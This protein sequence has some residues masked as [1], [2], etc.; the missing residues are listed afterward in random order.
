MSNFQKLC[1][2]IIDLE[3]PNLEELIVELKRIGTLEDRMERSKEVEA[4]KSSFYRQLGKLKAE[5]EAAGQNVAETFAGV[6]ENFK[7][8][9][10]DYKRERA[11]YNKAQDAL[12]QDNYEKKSALIAELKDLVDNIN[13]VQA[14]FPALR[15]IQAKW[16]EIGPVPETVF[17]EVNKSYQRQME[18]FYDMVQINHEL[19]DLDFKKNLEAKEELCAQAEELAK[20][21]N[22]ID[23][24]NSLQLLHEQWKEIG[25]V[26]KEFRDGIW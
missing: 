13:D 2:M 6:E 8:V 7:N 21:D 26:A 17:N 10:S 1:N 20:S 18:R 14:T 24:F 15:E 23:A 3:N 19:R 4:I 22:V 16:K 9:Y 25:P 11:E 5:A 12:R